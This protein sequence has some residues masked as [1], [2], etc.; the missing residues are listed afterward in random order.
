MSGTPASQPRQDEEVKTLAPGLRQSHSCLTDCLSGVPTNTSAC[1]DVLCCVRTPT[2]GRRPGPNSRQ[3][4]QHQQRL[5]LAGQD[6]VLEKL[7]R[8]ERDR[9]EKKLS[10]L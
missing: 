3:Q 10:L 9:E 4:Q 8:R 1:L 2:S 6:H 5:L 7:E